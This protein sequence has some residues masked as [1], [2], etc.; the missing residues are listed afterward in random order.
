[1]Y[2]KEW[3]ALIYKIGLLGTI[4]TYFAVRKVNLLPLKG[5]VL[6]FVVK[7]GKAPSAFI[8]R[9]GLSAANVIVG[10]EKLPPW[11]REPLSWPQNDNTAKC[12]L[13]FTNSNTTHRWG[14]WNSRQFM[15]KL[16]KL[17]LYHHLWILWQEK[18]LKSQVEHFKERNLDAF[19]I[20]LMW[21]S[22]RFIWNYEACWD[23][24]QCPFKAAKSIIYSR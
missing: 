22:C 10:R 2:V 7:E 18:L 3:L 21:H 12:C 15:T 5:K 17:L 20:F 8:R 13:A 24:N 19:R 4:I 14:C 16:L 23:G 9:L 6:S 11:V 1:M